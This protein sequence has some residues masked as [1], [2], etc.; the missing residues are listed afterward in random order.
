[1]MKTFI[2]FLFCFALANTAYCQ[3]KQLDYQYFREG[4]TYYAFSLF[5]DTT[6]A[7]R[8]LLL[9]FT[10]KSKFN[11]I[12]KISVTAGSIEVKL[13]FKVRTDSIQSDNTEQRS[14]SVV[15]NAKDIAEKQLGCDGQITFKLDNGESYTLPFNACLI[16]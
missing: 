12:E 14:Y 10:T 16:K 3:K 5:S 15:F 7:P 9:D 1:M 4:K 2:C 8:A 11:K 6:N 13:K